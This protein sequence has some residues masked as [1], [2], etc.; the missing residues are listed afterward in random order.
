M[1]QLIWA[2]FLIIIKC[3]NYRYSYKLLIICN[4]FFLYLQYVYNVV[5]VVSYSYWWHWCWVK[6]L[7]TNFMKLK[8]KIITRFCRVLNKIRG[9]SAESAPALWRVVKQVAAANC[10]SWDLSRDKS[11]FRR[12]GT[13]FP[14]KLFVEIIEDTFSLL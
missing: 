14:P 2:S 3:L 12:S 4:E 7:I 9:S 13:D 8:K 1:F 6:S 10:I 11:S 5:L